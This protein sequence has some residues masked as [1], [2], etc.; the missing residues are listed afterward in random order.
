[1]DRFT[2]VTQEKVASAMSLAYGD[3]GKLSL[4]EA[5]RPPAAAST[6]IPVSFVAEDKTFVASAYLSARRCRSGRL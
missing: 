2:R 5:V 1:M 6:A 3:Q 4:A